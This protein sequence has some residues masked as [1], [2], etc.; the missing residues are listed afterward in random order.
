MRDLIAVVS[1]AD[2]LAAFEPRLAEVLAELAGQSDEDAA[3]TIKAFEGE[4]KTVAGINPVKSMMS[5]ARRDLAKGKT[6]K[7]RDKLSQVSA[8]MADEIAWRQAAQDSVMPA[9]IAY[10]D[11]AAMT[12]GLRSQSR[13]PD[14][15]VPRISSCKAK[16][17]DISLRF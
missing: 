6:E 2:G 8:I 11:A 13:L 12:I 15:I 1:E 7:G 9:L 14:D 17:R 16:H 4:M 3:V 10:R 5:K